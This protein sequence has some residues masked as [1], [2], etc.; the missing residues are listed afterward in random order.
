MASKNYDRYVSN[1]L[2][3]DGSS[4]AEL[5]RVEVFVDFTKAANQLAAATDNLNL[6]TIPSESLILGGDIEQLVVG[7]SGN[8]LTVRVNTTAVSGALASDAVVGTNAGIAAASGLPISVS[9]AVDVNLL[10]ASGVR[11]TGMVRVWVYYLEGK[12]PVAM[13]GL[14]QRDF[15]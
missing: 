2:I 11:A 12:G 15:T 3:A 6:F 8:T 10:S 7:S 14:A 1:Q 4:P 5:R 13:P 9:S